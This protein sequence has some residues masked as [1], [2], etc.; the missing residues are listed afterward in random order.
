MR[1]LSA[2]LIVIAAAQILGGCAVL[3]YYRQ[4]AAGQLELMTRSRPI[5]DWIGDE[6]TNEETRAKLQNVLVMRHF[7][8]TEMQLPDNGSYL[9]YADLGR[10][11]VVWNVFATPEFSLTPIKSCFPIVGCLNYRGYFSRQAAEQQ[12]A[13]LKSEGHD[14]YVG[15]VAAY[16]TLGWFADPMLN[17]MLRWSEARLAA[18]LFH[19]LAHQKVYANNDSAFNEAFATAV[20]IIGVERWLRQQGKDKEWQEWEES[21]RFQLDFL[22][23][24]DTT[25]EELKAL[26]AG[27][28]P[29]AEMRRE[30]E[31]IYQEMRAAYGKL[32]SGKW[33]GYEGYD[34]WFATVNNARISAVSTYHKWVPAFMNLLAFH[35]GNLEGFYQDCL[36][37]SERSVDE[38]RA[39]LEQWLRP[40]VTDRMSPWNTNQTSRA[41]R[42]H[43]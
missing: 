13:S 43:P 5:T 28:L 14:V 38:R 31:R 21:R 16:S 42:H 3:E 18:V 1:R 35:E 33:G 40:E 2:V 7:A 8:M 4:S 32:K 34:H 24:V 37:V 25:A 17:T 20:G 11:H 6:S 15:G 39:W 27:D 26:Y 12:A 10:S 41:G 9:E 23:L 19:E 29:P 30:K 36:E 22:S